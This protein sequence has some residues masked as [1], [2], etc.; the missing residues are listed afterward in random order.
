M[1]PRYLTR[2]AI[3]DLPPRDASDDH[4]CIG[5]GEAKPSQGWLYAVM[6]SSILLM[7]LST[8]ITVALA[9]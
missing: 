9:A 2:D 7:R 6:L 4:R 5:E 8:F 3:V 1:W